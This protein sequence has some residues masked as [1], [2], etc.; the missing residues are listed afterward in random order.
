[1]ANTAYKQR[2]VD[3]MQD[4]EEDFDYETML[5]FFEYIESLDPVIMANMARS[6]NQQIAKEGLANPDMPNLV[7]PET[8]Q[9]MPMAGMTESIDSQDIPALDANNNL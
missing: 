3:Y 1:M 2:F 8:G 9:D 7:S 5:R 6:A 4:H